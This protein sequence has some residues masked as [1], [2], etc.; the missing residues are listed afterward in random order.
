MIINATIAAGAPAGYTTAINSAIQF[1]ESTFANDVTLNI[2]FKFQA[3]S[4]GLAK[5]SFLFMITITP[6]F[7]AR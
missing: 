6:T 2:T 7:S 4:V 1:F 3:L 5:S